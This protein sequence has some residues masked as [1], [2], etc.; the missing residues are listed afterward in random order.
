MSGTGHRRR[1]IV[2][3]NVMLFRVAPAIVIAAVAIV[4]YF[5][6]WRYDPRAFRGDG[7]LT[8]TGPRYP[9]YRIVFE[10]V[11]LSVSSHREY[12]FRGC[13]RETFTLELELACSDADMLDRDGTRLS[14][15][16]TDG[17][18]VAVSTA[19][20]TLD[21]WVLRES[22][23]GCGLWHP[24]FRDVRLAP[25]EPYLLTIDIATGEE[26]DI[27][28]VVHAVPVLSGGGYETP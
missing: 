11:Q 27:A 15:V 1:T 7:T 12:R 9:R 22:V 8:D 3:R 25:A 14:C 2:D 16:L 26:S 24:A 4:L 19:S 21:E 10:P 17:Q 23:I 20:G 5:V 28:T 18:G 6:F 13:P